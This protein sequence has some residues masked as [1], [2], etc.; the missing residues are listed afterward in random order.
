M[1]ARAIRCKRR[2]CRAPLAVVRGATLTLADGTRV[3]PAGVG[4]VVVGRC[5]RCGALQ[6]RWAVVEAETAG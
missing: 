2:A 5:G 6:A 4:T 1:T 3:G